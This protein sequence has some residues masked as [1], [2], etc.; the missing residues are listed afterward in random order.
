LIKN[1][2]N[3]LR[4]P[5]PRH[6]TP[7]PPDITHVM[8]APRPSPFLLFFRFCAILSIQ[9]EEPKPGRPGNEVREYSSA[10]ERSRE[11]LQEAHTHY[12]YLN[13]FRQQL[14]HSSTTIGHNPAII[15]KIKSKSV[16]VKFVALQ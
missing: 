4:G 1:Q 7:C 11:L 13:W 6:P 5:A 2:Q 3:L 9:T 10:S 16:Q 14:I 12:V 15:T 8:N